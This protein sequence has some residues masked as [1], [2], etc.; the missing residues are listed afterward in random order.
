MRAVPSTRRIVEAVLWALF[1][2]NL[3]VAVGGIIFLHQ[4]TWLYGVIG[5][6]GAGAMLLIADRIEL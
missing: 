1:A 3:T 5:A 4:P 6:I 2:G